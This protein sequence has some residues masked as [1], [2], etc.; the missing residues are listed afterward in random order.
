VLQMT[1]LA[2]LA[3]AHAF[4]FVSF[5]VMVARHGSLSAEANPIVVQIASHTGLEG[6]TIAKVATVVLAASIIV[7]VGRRH[8]ATAA[9]LLVFAVLAGVAGGVSNVISM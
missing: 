4:D 8:R 1:A 2:I 9:A 5:L 6:I 3:L 7:I